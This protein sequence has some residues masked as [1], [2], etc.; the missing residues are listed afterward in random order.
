M[1]FPTL[2]GA[3]V[4]V[5]MVKIDGARGLMAGAPVGACGPCGF[6]AGAAA[7]LSAGFSVGLAGGLGAGVGVGGAAVGATTRG[8]STLLP[9]DG[10]CCEPDGVDVPL[11]VAPLGNLT[12]VT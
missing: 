12:G 6:S 9:A 1:G 7:G 4:G 10:F 8:F 3:F 11:T 2:Y 5:G